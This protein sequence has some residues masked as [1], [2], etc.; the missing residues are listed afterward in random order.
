VTY[1]QREQLHVRMSA[2]TLRSF[3]EVSAIALDITEDATE[4]QNEVTQDGLAKDGNLRVLAPMVSYAM[5]CLLAVWQLVLFG[6]SLSQID[7]RQVGETQMTDQRFGALQQL[8]LPPAPAG[9][10][11]CQSGTL[12]AHRRAA[13]QSAAGNSLCHW[14]LRSGTRLSP[15]LASRSQ[16]RSPFL[17]RVSSRPERMAA[18]FSTPL[19]GGGNAPPFPSPVTFLVGENGS[20]KFTLLEAIAECCGFNPKGGSRD[21]QHPA[22][23]EPSDLACALRLAWLP[24][25]RDGSF[26]RAAR[27]MPSPTGS[28]SVAVRQPLLPGTRPSR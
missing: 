7:A 20:G 26:L 14:L 11:Q 6:G 27:S 18:A 1:Q 8:G 25:V 28:R 15:T 23:A 3:A 13:A 2:D 5:V 22:D 16:R 10:P 12:P 24:M 19:E 9:Q 17:R 21:H 4:E